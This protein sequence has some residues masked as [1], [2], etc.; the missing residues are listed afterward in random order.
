[1]KYISKGNLDE[2]YTEKILCDLNKN[3][4]ENVASLSKENLTQYIKNSSKI[5]CLDGKLYLINTINTEYYN[6]IDNSGK[7]EIIY[8]ASN[9][10]FI[11]RYNMDKSTFRDII[12]SYNINGDTLSF[13]RI[14]TVYGNM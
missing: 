7:Y 11:A 3:I 6:S 1:M 10:Y 12:F 5:Q 8:D 4:I 14:K 2:N 9:D 13:V